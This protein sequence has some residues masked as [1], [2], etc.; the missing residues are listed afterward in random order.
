MSEPSGQQMSWRVVGQS[1]A[2]RQTPGGGLAQGVDITY[3]LDNGV[4]GTVFVT[5]ND[6]RNVDTVR[7]LIGADAAHRA[8]VAGL[9]SG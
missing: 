6:Y 1:D 8:T 7:A 5:M 4:Q 2:T 3:E 9:T